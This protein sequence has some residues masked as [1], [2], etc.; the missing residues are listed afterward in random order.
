MEKET[1]PVTALDRRK[2]ADAL[3]RLVDIMARLRSPGGCPWDA[4][5]TDDTIKAYLLEEAYEV[6]EAV[7]R[8]S[9]P[10]VCQE[11]G[12]LLFQI[13]FLARLAEERGDF[14]LTDVMEGIAEKMIRRHP[15]VFGEARV[16]GAEE[17][18]SN[19]AKIKQAEKGNGQGA[20][21]QLRSIPSNLP[22]LLRCHR[23]TERASKA[24]FPVPSGMDAIEKI[25]K[26]VKTLKSSPGLATGPREEA[27][28]TLFFSAASAARAMGF[29]AEHLL[30]AANESF[31]EEAAKAEKD[32]TETGLSLEDAPK[33]KIQDA[34][35]RARSS[36][37]IRSAL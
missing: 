25:E 33:E 30:R 17:V 23:I 35:D 4:K 26:A 24:G 14:D 11:L 15:H 31:I 22:A 5:Q 21:A 32:L 19:W 13:I 1:S 7:E 37:D 28:R 9:P 6:L 10:D 12:D 20:A 3:L 36:N 27:L 2:A 29:N 16:E 8:A 18:A 34:I